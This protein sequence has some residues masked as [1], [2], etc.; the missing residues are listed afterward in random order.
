MDQIS[1]PLTMA[2]AST[3]KATLGQLKNLGFSVH[4]ELVHYL[5]LALPWRSRQLAQR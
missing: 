3:P 4:S 2:S 5:L 1:D